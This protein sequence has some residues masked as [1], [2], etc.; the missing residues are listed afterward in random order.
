MRTHQLFSTVL[1]SAFLFIS[2]SV[3]RE[4]VIE[5]SGTIEG[6]D[7]NIGTE[8]MGKIKEIYVDEGSLV[9]EG[10]TLMVIDDTDYEI[11]LRQAIANEEAAEAQYHLA[12]EGTRK[13]DI[14]Q[15]E[16]NFKNAESDYK[17]MK[18]LLESKTVTQKQYD[19]V[20][21]RYI[22][23]KQTYEK[24]VRGLRK[25]EIAMARARRDQVVAQAD[26]LRKKLNDCHLISPLKGTVTL[27][28]VEV[29][30]L[31][32]IGANVLRITYLDRVN[33]MI[34]VGEADLG[35]VR[36]GQT[37]KVTIDSYE[38]KSFDGRVVYISPVAEFTPKNVQ[39][40][41]ERTKL[42]FGV[43]IEVENPDGSLKP[44]LPADARI[45]VGHSSGN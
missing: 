39:T 23:S 4:G 21:T 41:E 33:L 27:K 8:V 38:N 19:D 36:L 16:A 32:R 42:V 44:G 45:E 13:E 20:Y 31:V 40:K 12:L 11:Q 7:V 28:A 1:I 22:S 37:A 26:L 2:C 9:E 14:L 29:G 10:D 30:E 34:Y 15:A 24:L 3:G 43:K 18:D 17:R 6:T 25:D 35:K 5:A